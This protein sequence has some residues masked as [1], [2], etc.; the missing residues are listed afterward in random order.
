MTGRSRDQ[1][2][3]V[4]AYAKRA[5]LWFDPHTDPRYTTVVELDLSSVEVSLAGPTRPQDRIPAGPPSKR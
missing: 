3:F 2:E 4:E 5:G 1:V